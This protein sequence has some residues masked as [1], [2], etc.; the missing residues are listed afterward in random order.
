MFWSIKFE[1]LFICFEIWDVVNGSDVIFVES[2]VIGF[3]VWKLCD[4]KV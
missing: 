3:V 4:V 2:D 1:L